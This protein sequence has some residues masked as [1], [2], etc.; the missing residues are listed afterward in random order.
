MGDVK[1]NE[2]TEEKIINKLDV[3]ELNNVSGGKKKGG[4]DN[5]AMVL[6]PKCHTYEWLRTTGNERTWFLFIKEYEWKCY[7]CQEVFW[8]RISHK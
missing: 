1:D 7:N 4:G 8:E 2:F 3:D 5:R 6:C